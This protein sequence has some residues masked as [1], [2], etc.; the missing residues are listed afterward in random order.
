M[1]LN[2][3]EFKPGHQL[4]EPPLIKAKSEDADKTKP[5]LK[6]VKNIDTKVELRLALEKHS[7]CQDAVEISSQFKSAYLAEIA[8][9]SPKRLALEQV[10]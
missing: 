10:T 1:T 7:K 6:T 3:K 2:S 4:E 8:E 9:F 5:K